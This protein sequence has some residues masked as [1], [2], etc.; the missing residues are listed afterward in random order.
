M[1]SLHD[2]VGKLE[3]SLARL[4]NQWRQQHSN[5]DLDAAQSSVKEYHRIFEELWQLGWRGEGLLP[6]S[7]LPDHLMSK[8]YLEQGKKSKGI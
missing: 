1:G 5:N 4:A 6:D 7:E 8:N 3:L 2:L